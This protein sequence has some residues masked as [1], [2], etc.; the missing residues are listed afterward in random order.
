MSTVV[1]DEKMLFKFR[2]ADTV[3]GVTRVTVKRIAKELGFN[4]TQAIHYALAKLAKEVLP[5]Y[6]QDDGPL[7]KQELA[8]IDKLEPQDQP[9]N[10]TKSLF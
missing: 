5:A 4:E 8:A 2:S 10:A 6:E 9:F 1:R 3:T 7:S